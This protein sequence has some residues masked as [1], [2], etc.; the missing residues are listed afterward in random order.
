LRRLLAVLAGGAILLGAAAPVS[1]DS[2]TWGYNTARNRTTTAP[3]AGLAGTTGAGEMNPGPAFVAPVPGQSQSTPIVVGNQWYQFSYWDSGQAGALWTGQLLP[4]G[5]S[6]SAHGVLTLTAEPG[7][8]FS[9]PADA[10]ISPDGKWMAFEAGMRIWWWPTGDP[11]A[12]VVQ[13]VSG[14]GYMSASSVS[15]T[16]VPAPSAPS[17]W[18]VCAGNWN[19]SEY[20]Y[21]V[22]SNAQILQAGGFEPD[23]VYLATFGNANQHAAY[24]TAPITSSA[25]YDPSTGDIYFGVASNSAPRL[26]AMNPLTGAYYDAGLG[27]VRYAIWA[28]TAVR[29]GNVYAS[30]LYGDLYRFD[31]ASGALLQW[32]QAGNCG[33][34]N[35][36]SPVVTPGSV[37]MVG[38]NYRKAMQFNPT[39]LAMEW[40]S[41]ANFGFGQSSDLTAVLGGKN[42]Q[43]VYASTIGGVDD[44]V[45]ATPPPY[46]VPAWDTIGPGG[47]GYFSSAVVVGR[48][49][50]V[51]NDGA[52]PF[53][54]QQKAPMAAQPWAEGEGPGG[55]QIFHIN[56]QMALF[57]TH[58][59]FIIGQTKDVTAVALVTPGAT[60]TVDGGYWGKGY[61]FT[62]AQLQPGDA[63]C[64]GGPAGFFPQKGIQPC[65]PWSSEIPQLTTFA[66]KYSRKKNH[67][68]YVGPSPVRLA[69]V[70]DG[71][72]DA[73]QLT[74][75]VAGITVPDGNYVGE[76]GYGIQVTAAAPGAGPVTGTAYTVAACPSSEFAD[77]TAYVVHCAPDSQ[78]VFVKPTPK[79][80]YKLQ[81]ES[82]LICGTTPI[83][84]LHNC[85]Y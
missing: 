55:L 72:Y 34:V 43:I 65:G 7:E 31:A 83:E 47:L 81:V 27:Q 82:A 59:H 39:S 26:V 58:R 23:Y 62:A 74:L 25:S 24:G 75:P 42:T 66:A 10:A 84:K 17:G 1:A 3:I 67:P 63:S 19:G 8:S 68:S 2:Y 51:W 15:P 45:P 6:T 37:Y 11:S 16:F 44:V 30:D 49:V 53:W 85:G 60:V 13:S 54:Q 28:S 73:Y 22:A 14:P 48:D 5:R 33:G 35:I 69:G 9:Q 52:V 77:I 38:C 61:T 41:P 29:G 4:G 56:T 32:T 18:A 50:L 20:C 36:D 46:L 64:G 80:S 40:G 12:K 79:P 70:L 21:P 71:G 78:D 57:F 76:P